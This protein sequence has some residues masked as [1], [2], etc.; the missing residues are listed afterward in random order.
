MTIST[1][2]ESEIPEYTIPFTLVRNT[3]PA[4]TAVI[5]MVAAGHHPKCRMT[6]GQAIATVYATGVQII[7]VEDG[8]GTDAATCSASATVFTPVSLTLIKDQVFER[9]E[10]INCVV[11][12]AGSAT[13]SVLIVAQFENIH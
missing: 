9:N 7:A 13:N 5:E 8:G 10:S 1:I 4:S 12:T 6:G 2:E 3:V 11:S